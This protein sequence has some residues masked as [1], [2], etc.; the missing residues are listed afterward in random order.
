VQ[1]LGTVGYLSAPIIKVS[2]LITNEIQ[3]STLTLLNYRSLPPPEEGIPIDGYSYTLFVSSGNFY[4]GD[5]GLMD[6]SSGLPS[7]SNQIITDTLFTST[8]FSYSQNF[9]TSSLTVSSI[10]FGTDFG[11]L[12][13]GDVQIDTLSSSRVNTSNLYI[14]DS[15]LTV[16][17][18]I[19]SA[20]LQ[21]L[22]IN[23]LYVNTFGPVRVKKSTLGA[24][25]LQLEAYDISKYFLFT[26][27]NAGYSVALPTYDESF[28][29]WNCVI[30][31][32]PNSTEA[33]AISTVKDPPAGTNI[34]PG[35]TVTILGSENSY[36]IL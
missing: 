26:Q 13:L 18:Y 21:N 36:N 4:I 6:P 16:S 28:D 2:N 3:T 17:S 25:H 8:T 5:A 24:H 1:G 20:E 9:T 12:N 15:L 27:M 23:N 19:S 35:T 29:G 31:N 22:Q 32:M 7:Q 33:F 34:A 30:R 10:S 11:F 14:N